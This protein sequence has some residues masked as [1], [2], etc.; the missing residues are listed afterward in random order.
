MGVFPRPSWART[1]NA[2]PGKPPLTLH[3]TFS[4]QTHGGERG[5][6]GARH[7]VLR[8]PGLAVCLV[9]LHRARRLLDNCGGDLF[10]IIEH[11]FRL[12][13]GSNLTQAPYCWRL[14]FPVVTLGFPKRNLS[15]GAK[16]VS[17]SPLSGA[18]RR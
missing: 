7:Q 9:D 6:Y 14:V 13:S 4:V 12:Q 2:Q 17:M 8:I 18:P 15:G 11:L 16:A 1:P 3:V 10:D 5:F